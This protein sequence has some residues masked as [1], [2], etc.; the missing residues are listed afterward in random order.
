LPQQPLFALAESLDLSVLA[1]ALQLF[2][3]AIVASWLKKLADLVVGSITFRMNRYVSLGAEVEVDGIIKGTISSVTWTSIKVSNQEE[4][5][6]V[7]T[8]RWMWRTW[9]FKR[10]G[11]D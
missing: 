2:L 7:P 3:A 10:R 5:L 11:G 1:W 6:V 8:S 9:K 4:F